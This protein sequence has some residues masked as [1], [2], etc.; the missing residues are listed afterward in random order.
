M[1]EVTERTRLWTR[2]FRGGELDVTVW[3]Q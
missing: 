3:V 1:G 2:L